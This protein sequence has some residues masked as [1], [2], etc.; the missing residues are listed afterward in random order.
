MNPTLWTA[1]IGIWVIAVGATVLALV[2]INR[3]RRK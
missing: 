1:F 2:G 3:I